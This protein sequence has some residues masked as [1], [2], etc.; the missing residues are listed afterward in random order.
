MALMCNVVNVL[1]HTTCGSDI[2]WVLLLNVFDLIYSD[3]CSSSHRESILNY[4]I[5]AVVIMFVRHNLTL[6]THSET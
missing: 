2:L 6:F 5:Q 4:I 1:S 3:V